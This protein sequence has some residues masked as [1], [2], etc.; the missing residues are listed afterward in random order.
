M[1][2]LSSEEKTGLRPVFISSKIFLF[3][4]L[5]STKSFTQI[6][7]NGFCKYDKLS[8]PQGFTNIFSFNYN[9]DSYTDLLLFN[10]LK[11]ESA[12]LTGE[13]N[14]QFS[15]P[16]KI[17]FSFEPAQFKPV[18]DSLL[19]ISYY[20]FTSRRSRIFGIL[21]FNENGNPTIIHSV[22]LNSYPEVIDATN[23]DYKGKTTFLVCGKSFDGIS[24]FTITDEKLEEEK[25][26]SGTSFS[27]AQFIHLNSDDIIDIF[28]YNLLERS[29]FFLVNN[30]RNEFN[31][32]RKIHT[33]EQINFLQIFDLNSDSFKDIIFSDKSGIK[34]LFGDPLYL[35]EKRT[36]IPTE[37]DAETIAVAD[38]NHDGMFD[39]LYSSK[40]GGIVSAIFAKNQISFF[41]EIIYLQTTSVSEIIPFF[42][43]FVYG[44]VY[45]NEAGELGILSQLTSFKDDLTLTMAVS[46]EE[47]ISFDYNNNGINDLAFIDNY[48]KRLKFL[49]RNNLGI[50][51]IYFSV[52]L[53]GTHKKSVCFDK[54]DSGKIFYSF[55]PDERLIEILSVDFSSFNFKRENLY[56]EGK[57][58]DLMVTP[59]TES[60]PNIHLLIHKNNKLLYGVYTFSS[61]KYVFVSYTEISENW[62]DALIL[63]PFENLIAYW[64]TNSTKFQLVFNKYL[65]HSSSRQIIYSLSTESKI[66][67]FSTRTL[68]SEDLFIYSSAVEDKSRFRLLIFDQNLAVYSKKLTQSRLQ[69]NAVNRITNV[70]HISFGN[71]NLLYFY[72]EALKNFN[73]VFVNRYYN[74]FNVIKIFDNIYIKNFLV[75]KLDTRNKHL[76]YI[77]SADNLIK[78]KKIL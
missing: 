54:S 1:K 77:D 46:P 30:G 34:I 20:A 45:L 58:I 78:V 60:R 65:T 29:F 71:D 4:L 16:K 36:T 49:L 26:I 62:F 18:Y 32:S 51:A 31:V 9:K 75:T 7:I 21:N 14:L 76:V 19:Q 59:S 66:K 17:K 13:K 61:I 35:F 44:A 38:F 23:A 3:I 63:N 12:L 64:T 55:S 53:F 48:D 11:N 15:N 69:G 73:K 74:R 40:D 39:L 52:K 56:A 10:P 37:F 41:D 42:S 6:P 70:N 33:D 22:K 2:K 24:L 72:D 25:V 28:A 67:T 68:L 27:F 5:F 8:V 57:I 43:K 47:V 50:P